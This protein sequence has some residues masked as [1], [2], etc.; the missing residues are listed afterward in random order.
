MM[1]VQKL[2]DKSIIN[3]MRH[4]LGS[5]LA[6]KIVPSGGVRRSGV[7]NAMPQTSYLRI[8]N[9]SFRVKSLNLM[10]FGFLGK[11]R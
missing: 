1:I 9:T 6:A 5:M 10:G 4:L 3:F 2:K 11:N 7:K 8:N